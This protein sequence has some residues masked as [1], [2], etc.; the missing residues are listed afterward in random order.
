VNVG[1][2]PF[3]ALATLSCIAALVGCSGGDDDSGAA[4]PAGGSSGSGTSASGGMGGGSAGKGGA[5]GSSGSAGK[6]GSA[7]GGSGGTGATGGGS[8]GTDAQAGESGTAGGN[9]YPPGDPGCGLDAAAFCDN[10]DAPAKTQGRAGEL[11][12]D[13]WSGSRMQ[14]DSPTAGGNQAFGVIPATLRPSRAVSGKSTQLPACRA[15]LPE[16]VSPDRDTLVCDPNSDIGSNHLLVAVS[17]QNYGQNSYRIRQ[18]FDFAG[19]TGKVVFDAEGMSGGILGWIS[20]DITEDPIAAPSFQ[21][22]QNL[23]GGILP[24]SALTVQFGQTCGDA[25]TVGVSQV[26]VVD[27]YTE[28]AMPDDNPPCAAAAWGKLNHFEISVSKTHLDVQVTPASEDG[29]TFGAPMTLWSGDV[30]LPFTRGYVQ[31]TTHNH[32]TLKYSADPGFARG[33]DALDAWIARWDNVG[34]DGPV[35]KTSREYEIPDSLEPGMDQNGKSVT[36]TGYILGD[37]T[38]SAGPTLEFQN[39]DVKGVTKATVALSAWY[40]LGCT[41]ADDVARFALRYRLNGNDWIE[42]PFTAGEV[43]NLTSGKARGAVAHLLDVPVEQ[44]VSGKN[45]LELEGV[46]MPR[47]YP[48]GVSNVDL[49]LDTE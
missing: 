43:G 48:P 28:E 16:T 23:E 37:E 18:P 41:T 1:R 15:G 39:V 49:I 21:A 38:T 36:N 35:I 40:C 13:K 8:S 22:Q 17:G 5:G 24:R 33:F 4:P 2:A 31:I 11:D 32:A 42:R 20:L 12:P 19:R 34:F 3:A 45:T 44:L 10:F 29:T 25:D 47:N 7:N 27:D 46:N 30:S 26:H 14:P 6:S 9:N